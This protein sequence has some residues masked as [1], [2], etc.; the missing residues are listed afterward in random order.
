MIKFQLKYALI[1]RPKFQIQ[2]QR[3]EIE[4]ETRSQF[5]FL[6]NFNILINFF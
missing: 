3:A 1:V 2:P 4:I 5:F 6:Q